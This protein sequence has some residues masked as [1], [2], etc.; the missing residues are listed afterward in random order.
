MITVEG[1]DGSGKTTLCSGLL[2]ALTESGLEVRLLREPG[3]VEAAERIRQLV[4]DACLHIAPRCEALLFAAARA[5]LVEEAIEPLLQAGTWV[6]LDRFVDSSLAYQGA[7]RQLG[8]REVAE[9]NAFATQGLAPDRTLLLVI[10]PDV[11]RARA[12]S[13][14]TLADRLEQEHDD[15]F[16][17]VA[18]AY[19][20]LAASDPARIRA[21]DAEQ[22]PERVLTAALSELADLLRLGAQ[23]RRR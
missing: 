8:M 23:L 14:G 13:R 9:I 17:R 3:G 1:L 19:A 11:G 18:E 10:P 20:Q 6:I 15:F 2:E 22:S 4:H 5:Q 7:G 12:R 16:E 21:V